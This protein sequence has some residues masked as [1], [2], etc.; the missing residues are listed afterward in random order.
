[1]RV[2]VDNSVWVAYLR[3]TPEVPL[4]DWLIESVPLN[5]Q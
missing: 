3:G 4:V 1:M 2:L 5:L